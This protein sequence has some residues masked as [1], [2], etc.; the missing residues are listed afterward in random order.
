MIRTSK[1]RNVEVV[2]WCDQHLRQRTDQVSVPGRL[3][4]PDELRCTWAESAREAGGPRL[5][6]LQGARKRFLRC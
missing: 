1:V 4:V 2:W 5:E 3:V 6:L